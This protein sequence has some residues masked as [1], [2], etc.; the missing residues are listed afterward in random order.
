VLLFQENVWL[1]NGVPK[2]FEKYVEF[3]ANIYAVNLNVLE[4]KT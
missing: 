1:F 2:I 3:N 4:L